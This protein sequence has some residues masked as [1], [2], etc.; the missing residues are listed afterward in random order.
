MSDF[1]WISD[2]KGSWEIN[3]LQCEK[4]KHKEQNP[5]KCKMYPEKKPREV[6]KRLE[7]CPRFNKIDH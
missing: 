2:I 1:R 6:L 7:P 5:L 4:C 3:E